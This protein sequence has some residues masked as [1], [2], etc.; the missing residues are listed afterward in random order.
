MAAA[1]SELELRIENLLRSLALQHAVA[2]VLAESDSLAEAVPR[3]LGAA[4]AN[5]GYEVGAL[6][7]LDETNGVLGCLGA[8]QAPGVEAEAFLKESRGRT[9]EIGVGLPGR[10][11]QSR[12]SA[13]IGDVRT[14]P[15]FPRAHAAALAGLQGGVAV[16]LLVQDEVTGVLELFSRG[17]RTLDEDLLR[18]F[19][20]IGGQVGQFLQR[21]RVAEGLREAHR[22]L[23][24]AQSRL[25]ASEKLAGLGQLVAGVAHEINNPLA[26][27]TNNMAVLER[28]AREL[29]EL[30]DLYRQASRAGPNEVE[31]IAKRI[32]DAEA[33][34]EQQKILETIEGLLP[35]TREGLRRIQQIVKD[36][37]DFA[38]LDFGGLEDA[39]LNAGVESTVNIIRG[40]ANKAQVALVLDLEPLPRVRC[41]GAKINQVVMNLVANAID[42]CVPGGKV[43]LRTRAV[44]GGVEISVED[45]GAGIDPAVRDRLFDPFFTT[46]PVGQGTG[47]GLS[48]SYGIVQDHGGRIEVESEVGKGSRFAVWLPLTPVR[49]ESRKA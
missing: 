49:R 48:I 27:V 47:L 34:V 2:R 40:R 42:A 25:V 29:K 17:S 23:Q 41:F 45:D 15:N 46:K 19:E 24:D 9:F 36:L 38:R 3:I 16:P 11:W 37:R 33:A 4:G 30:L 43:T 10:V 26:F 39:D 12:R 20:T 1:V 31:A 7:V 32:R 22:S 35:R 44:A 5:V 28:E 6:W 8:W 14:D 18:T 13:S 21:V